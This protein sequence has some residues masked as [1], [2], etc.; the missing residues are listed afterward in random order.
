MQIY[1][2]ISLTYIFSIY[3]FTS[4]VQLCCTVVVFS[5]NFCKFVS[6]SCIAV[7]LFTTFPLF[8]CTQE[9]GVLSLSHLYSLKTKIPQCH[10]VMTL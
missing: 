6:Y 1:A 9:L 5:S 3:S 2:D 10:Y 7:L 8:A 4:R